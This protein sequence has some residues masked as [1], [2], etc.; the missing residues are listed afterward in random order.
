MANAEELGGTA[1]IGAASSWSRGAPGVPE[2][3]GP[4]AAAWLGSFGLNILGLGLPIVILQVYD[5]ILPYQ[6][7]HTLALL[8]A[9][10]VLVLMMDGLIR[11]ARGA[12]TGWNAAKFEHLASCR[13]L[14]RLLAEPVGEFERHPPG[15][16]LDR[17]SAIN[18][19]RDFHAGQAKILL[20]DFPFITLFLGLI[21]F[22]AGWLVLVPIGIF[23]VLALLAGL[24]GLSLRRALEQR[25]VLDDRRYSFV[26]EVLAGLSTIKLLGVEPLMQ[27]RYERLQ[28]STAL[29]SHAVTLISN[30]AQ[31]MGWLFSNLTM[32]SVAAGGAVIVM[33]GGLSIGG[34]AASTL[35][36]GRSVQP[37]LRALGLW[38]QY[39][40]IAIARERVGKIFETPAEAP[41]AGIACGDLEGAIRIDGLG[42]SYDG[43]KTALIDD[44]NLEVSPGE[45][46]GIN[47]QSGSGKTTFLMLVMG[48][49]QPSKGKVEIDG[50]DMARLDPYELRRH[51][52]F[53][54]QTG[55]LFKG[56]ILDNL[57]L[58]QGASAVAPA[59]EAAR[60]VGIDD[61]I[62][63]L[64]EGYQM[65]VGD[66]AATEIPTGLRQGIAMARALARGPRIILFDEANGGLDSASD[67][68]LKKALAALKG[69][70]TII[71]VSHRPSLLELADRRYKLS[72]GRLLP[73]D[74][75]SRGRPTVEAGG[76]SKEL[77]HQTG[78]TG[79]SQ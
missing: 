7:T 21:Y 28:K 27:R 79:S 45:V 42:F 72:G 57:T 61:T 70:V 40:S 31:S 53:L 66:G 68:R 52:A 58:F 2:V 39:Q 59:L 30:V 78:K 56:T 9:G 3:P 37:V 29:A 34:L 6:A 46:I 23:V 71:M 25:A 74:E 54:P 36:A 26:I 15:V 4:G 11:V 19:L 67:A 22:I 73:A 20:L 5:R 41:H 43:E 62:R 35:L 77:P 48:L 60:L 16:H 49:L 55:T 50:V 1:L 32:V 76:Q 17:L 65:E 8:I 47:G 24:V 33:E 12:I 69:K 13:A 51:I 10:L 38:S 63:H 44:L 75:T 14:D 18:V 64:P